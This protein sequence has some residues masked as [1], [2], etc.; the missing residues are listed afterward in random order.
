M[1]D[2]VAAA[3]GDIALV[4][5]VSMLFGRLAARCGQPPVIGQIRAG[6]ALG[7]S[8]L[9]RLPGHLTV[10]LFPAGALLSL[11][12]IAQ[13][14]V[15][16]AM[17]VVAYELDWQRFGLPRRVQA[18]IA[19]AALLVPMGL[20]AGAALTLR[21][22]FAALGEPHLSRS[23][24]LFTGVA[25]SI[26]ALPVL[27][28]IVRERGISGS[29][30]SV[31]ATAAAGIMDVAAWL[32]LA[33]VLSGTVSKDGR[34]WPLTLL[35][36]GGFAALMLLAVRPALRHWINR[37]RSIPPERLPVVLALV[38]A[39]AWVTTSL[40][41]HPVFGGFLAGLAMPRTG[42][43]TPTCCVPWKKSAPCCCRSSSWWP[44]CR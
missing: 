13:V 17:F 36:F 33:V 3:M 37:R 9:G 14:A 5:M 38:L 19:A 24:V 43:P 25:V 41:L 31:A 8:V 27:A 39:S 16:I 34:P 32:I 44:A 1:D 15:V 23:L 20:G 30:A 7:P 40:G 11:N 2:I 26:T 28:A 21:S 4:L 22:Q 12:V 42:S 6:I 35:L 10:R 18:L 29:T